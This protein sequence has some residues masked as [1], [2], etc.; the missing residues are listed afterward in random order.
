MVRLTLLTLIIVAPAIVAADQPLDPNTLFAQSLT[1]QMALK[2]GREALQKADSKAAIDAL[3]PHVVKCNGST[4][5]LMTLRDAYAAYV[6]Q[7]QLKGQDDLCKVY[8]ER[9]RILD[10][11]ANIDA[12]PVPPQRPPEV[13]RGTRLE[14]DPL[15]QTPKRSSPPPANLLADAE[16]AFGDKRYGE[17]ERLFSQAFG[18]ATEVPLPHGPQWAYCKI[19][20]VVERLKQSSDGVP[21]NAEAEIAVASRLTNGDPKLDS[22][23]KNLMGELQ[24][25]KGGAPSIPAVAAQHTPKGDDGWAKVQT[26]NFRVY[27]DQPQEFAE[28]VAKAAEAA[29]ATAMT[30]W[31]G[32]GKAWSKPCDI[33]IHASAQDYAKA[34]GKPAT[35]PGHA[36]LQMKDSSVERRRVDLR[37][38]EPNTVSNVVPHE[39]THLVL[40]DLFDAP[41]PRWADEGMAVLA[42]PRSHVDRYLRTLVSSW[43]QGKL[44]P[45]AQVLKQPDYPDAAA[46]T[47]FYVESVSLVDFLVEEK[48]PE[49][50]VAFLRDVQHNA[51]IDAAI[52][53]HYGFANGQEMQNRWL[54]KYVGEEWRTRAASRGK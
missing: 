5:Y 29:R 34:T 36:T 2:Q 30:K 39:A 42:E 23:I 11:N 46:I 45:L 19:F 6:K 32:D 21:A 20:T 35:G 9:L 18:N 38:D 25:R 3:E 53:K 27:H 13:A 7:L 14:D 31:G 15:Q 50:L 43:K 48:G 4:E 22:Y 54:T 52:K 41:L 37:A 24:L 12:K 49:T 47:A 44:V 51:G 40:A 33:Y 17:A 8:L 26:T 16:K 28:Q 10:R 1:V